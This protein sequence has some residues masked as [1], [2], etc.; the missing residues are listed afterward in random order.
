M[1]ARVGGL[2]I[3]TSVTVRTHGQFARWLAS[4]GLPVRSP[5]LGSANSGMTGRC[6]GEAGV[7]T[8]ASF[9]GRR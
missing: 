9:S 6:L 7:N 1:P 2:D 5:Y 8:Y 4:R 3:Y